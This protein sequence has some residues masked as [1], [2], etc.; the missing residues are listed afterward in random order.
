MLWQSF[1][2]SLAPWTLKPILRKLFEDTRYLSTSRPKL[3][4]WKKINVFLA[5]CVHP[6]NFFPVF[7]C[8]YIIYFTCVPFCTYTHFIIFCVLWRIQKY[9]TAVMEV[10]CVSYFKTWHQPSWTG[11]ILATNYFWYFDS[12]LITAAAWNQRYFV[13][14]TNRIKST[15]LYSTQGMILMYKGT[16]SFFRSSFFFFFAILLFHKKYFII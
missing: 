12:K 13:N 8:S 10:M 4:V 6:V 7:S 9:F 15:K 2:F 1:T 5:M 14:T 3:W 11:T 16:F